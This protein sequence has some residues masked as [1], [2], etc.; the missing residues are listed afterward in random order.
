MQTRIDLLKKH[1]PF[2]KMDQA[3]LDFLAQHLVETTYPSGS[4]LIGPNQEAADRLF[5]IKSG[6]IRGERPEEKGSILWELSPGEMFPL[7]ALLGG[8]SVR[9]RYVAAEESVCLTLEKAHFLTLIERSGAFG[10]FSSRRLANLLDQALTQTRAETAADMGRDNALSATLASC[11]RRKPI[12]CLQS[13]TLQSVLETMRAENIGSMVMVD[14]AGRPAGVFTLRD[15]LSR[16]VLAGYDLA[17]SV[18]G[19]MTQNPVTL[20]ASAFAFEAALLMADHG[21][22]HLCIVDEGGRLKGVISEG[23][24][25]SL[26]RVSLANLSRTIQRAES[27]DRLS[28]LSADIQT[29]IGQM[30]A[31]GVQIDQITQL[32]TLLN[33]HLTRRVIELVLAQKGDPGIPFAWLSFGSEGRGEQTLKTDQDNGMLFEVPQ[34]ETPEAVRARLLPLAKAIN[35]ALALCGFPLCDGNIMASNPECCLSYDEWQKRFTRWIDQGNPEHLLKSS[36]FFD[37]RVLWGQEESA[38]RLKSW[39]LSACAKNPRFLK[40]MAASALQCRPPLGLLG[41]FKLSGKGEHEGELDLKK[42]GVTPFVDA[43]RIIALSSGIEATGTPA[44][45]EAAA[46][47][48][49]LKEADVQSWLSAYRFIQLIRIQNHRDQALA[50]RALSNHINPKKLGDLEQRVLKEA[51]RQIRKLQNLLEIRYQL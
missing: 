3:A 41:D 37:F 11:L 33:D 26:Q 34:G 45:L 15:L 19:V 46:Q 43:A 49:A 20:P 36:I 10:D 50:G 12:T 8:R 18:A 27:I 31:G 32:I 42:N 13:D 39:L 21:F 17:G 6:R 9:N 24:L 44:R 30:I 5:I 40:Q 22:H 1:A 48:Q 28:Q 35:D 14:E 7:G 16:V 2:D 38:N 23:D 25:F 51:F 47:K 29:L 4:E